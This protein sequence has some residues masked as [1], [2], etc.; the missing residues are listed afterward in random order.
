MGSLRSVMI[1]ALGLSGMRILARRVKVDM[2]EDYIVSTVFL[3]VDYNVFD[4]PPILW[5]TM[6]LKSK[7]AL[8]FHRCTGSR[9]QALAM[10]AAMKKKMRTQKLHKDLIRIGLGEG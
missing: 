1:L 6:V 2:I 8:W 7:D 9:E 4:G 10:H 5:E 3:G